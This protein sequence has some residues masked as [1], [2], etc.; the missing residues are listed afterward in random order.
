[1][2]LFLA[3]FSL[4]SPKPRNSSHRKGLVNKSSQRIKRDVFQIRQYRKTI[5]LSDQVRIY[6]PAYSTHDLQ[7]SKQIQTK[8]NSETFLSI[9]SFLQEF[10][11]GE[12]QRSIFSQVRLN[13]RPLLLSRTPKYLLKQKG[14][15]C[16]CN[17]T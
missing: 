4:F 5:V 1:M 13:F 3:N 2:Q 14:R 6:L 7:Q 10:F 15:F 8:A 16:Y 12:D 11:S 17:S 9:L